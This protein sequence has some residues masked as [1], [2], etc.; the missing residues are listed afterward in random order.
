MLLCLHFSLYFCA[1]GCALIAICVAYRMVSR[2]SRM[3]FSYRAIEA[4][5]E[6]LHQRLTDLHRQQL[7]LRQLT[8]NIDTALVVCTPS[9]HIDWMNQAAREYFGQD[10]ATVPEA[11]MDAV[12]ERRDEVDGHALSSALISID[13]RRSI[14][15]TLKDVSSLMSRR[16]MEAW[17]QLIRVLTH[18]I[19][20]SL[21]PII[22]ISDTL[23]DENEAFSVI[24]RRCRSLMEFVEGYRRLT[25]IG[26]PE[27]TEFS[28]AD[29]FAHLHQLYPEVSFPDTASIDGRTLYADRTQ[30]EQVMI[31]LLTNAR[32]SGAT[33]IEVSMP[34]ATT[35]SVADNGRGIPPDVGGRIF[36]PFFTTKP[37]GS[38]IGLSL[39]RQVM[40]E[41]GGTIGVE[42]KEGEGTVFTLCVS[43]R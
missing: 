42:S 28:V 40:I 25:R 4:E 7:Y 12:A 21:T 41:H 29:F 11:V 16:E 6:R 3:R 43:A 2:I 5:I 39:C 9:G 22:S 36:L 30:M 10:A 23:S 27:R 19:M 15:I 13:G 18:E 32:E 14:I 33:R 24:N 37:Q 26:R 34:D 8:E 38:G 35:I 31:N 1:T 17:Q 20:N